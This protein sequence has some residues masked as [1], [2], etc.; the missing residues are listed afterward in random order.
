MAQSLLPAE[1]IE[2][3]ILFIRQQK[4]LLD[5][6]LADLYQVETKQLVRAVKRN[7]GRFPNDFMF[8]LNNVEVA[9]LKSQ[10]GTTRSCGPLFG[11]AKFYLLIPIWLANWSSLRKNMMVNFVSCLKRF[12]N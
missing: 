4:V 1:R 8:Q 10:F 3:S 6:D 7:L 11:S 2:K 9:N 12:A 5:T